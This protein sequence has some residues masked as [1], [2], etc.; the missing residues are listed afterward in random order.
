MWRNKL[1]AILPLS[2]MT[3]FLF[4]GASLLAIVSGA[5]LTIASKLAPTRPDWFMRLVEIRINYYPYTP[6]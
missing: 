1:G 3:T 5:T 6:T 4:V 2:L